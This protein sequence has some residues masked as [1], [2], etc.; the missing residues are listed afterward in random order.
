MIILDAYVVFKGVITVTNP[1][2]TKRNKIVAF[3]N[4]AP[5][6]SYISK[7]DNVLIVNAEDLDVVMPICNLLEY[8]KNYYRDEPSN[9]LFS[10]S[11]SFRYKTSITGNTYGGDD[12]E[13]VDKNETEIVV[14]LKHLSNFWR[15]LDI[16]LI[17][18]QIELNLTWSKSCVS[19]DMTVRD[20]G[21]NDDSPAIIAPTGL[22]F[23]IKDTKLYVPVVS[24]PAK[25]DNKL[26]VQLKKRFKRI[27]KWNKYRSQMTIQSNNNNLNN[28][29]DPTFLQKSTDYLH[30]HLKEL[31]K[32]IMQQKT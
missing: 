14:P 19:A 1:D 17:Y 9:P 7:I 32:K 26:L 27:I 21:N 4:N 10:N 24:L 25:N 15:T 28:L 16:P 29:I 30:Y 11:E 5:F 31:L 18:C 2:N 13:K 6:I 20:A 12:T 22:E 23:Q 3:E 8:S